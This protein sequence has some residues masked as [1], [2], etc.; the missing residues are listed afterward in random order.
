MAER[1]DSVP[2][3]Y[4]SDDD[5]QDD[6]DYY[7]VGWSDEEEERGEE[8][9]NELAANVDPEYYEFKCLTQR[10]DVVGYLDTQAEKLVATLRGKC[11]VS[12]PEVVSSATCDRI[13]T[14]VVFQ[15]VYLWHV[16]WVVPSTHLYYCLLHIVSIKAALRIIFLF[17]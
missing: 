11:T 3:S 17:G 9:L 1:L 2:E 13:G 10:S 14:C 7:Y 15:F 16:V 8:E 12:A 4:C 5:L 6:L